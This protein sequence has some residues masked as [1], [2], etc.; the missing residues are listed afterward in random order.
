MCSNPNV[1]TCIAVTAT[2]VMLLKETR[3]NLI[4]SHFFKYSR[5]NEIHL[6]HRSTRESAHRFLYVAGCMFCLATCTAVES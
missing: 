6:L 3:H 4:F 2:T 5:L 1:Y